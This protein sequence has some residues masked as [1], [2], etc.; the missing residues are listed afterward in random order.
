MELCR[1][2]L[3]WQG[4]ELKLHFILIF[5]INIKQPLNVIKHIIYL[6]VAQKKITCLSKNH[7]VLN[8]KGLI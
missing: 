4:K 5:P 7:G 8:S 6:Q 2:D 1:E 3:R